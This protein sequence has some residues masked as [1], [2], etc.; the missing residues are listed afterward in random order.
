MSNNFDSTLV[1]KIYEL[2]TED[3][4]DQIL[5]T[6]LLSYPAVFSVGNNQ[7]QIFEKIE[8]ATT[9]LLTKARP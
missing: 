3:Y 7:R 8:N 2:R 5:G 6:S 1:I 4:T 9:Q